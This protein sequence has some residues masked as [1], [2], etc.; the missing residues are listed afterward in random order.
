MTHKG[1]CVLLAAALAVGAGC[2]SAKFS[3]AGFQLPAD[4][5][6]EKG[7]QA[8]VALG[9][10]SCH[11]L[12]GTELDRNGA[13][14]ASPVMLGG[15]VVHRFSDGYL[16][17][18]MIHPNHQLAAY[19]NAQITDNGVSR[20]PS[21]A[22]RMTVRQMIDIVAFLQANYQERTTPPSYTPMTP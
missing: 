3:P 19:P 5:N 22:D 14:S 7:K 20:M 6:V 13:Q 16:V 4:G 21:Y 10:P 2:R 15:D 8:F 18:S 1:T 12:N 11:Q 9:C 17:T